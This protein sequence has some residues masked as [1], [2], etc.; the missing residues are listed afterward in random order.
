MHF[1]HPSDAVR[2]AKVSEK[3]QFV[4]RAQNKGYWV[5]AVLLKKSNRIFHY[6]PIARDPVLVKCRQFSVLRL[7]RGSLGSLQ[8]KLTVFQL[9]DSA[10]EPT[11][12]I[13]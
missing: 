1:F 6:F 5:R 4:S 8:S 13:H 3:T 10:A 7:T 12:L 2:P 9:L 11:F